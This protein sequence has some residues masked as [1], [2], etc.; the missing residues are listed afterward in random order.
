M[1]IH[2]KHIFSLLSLVVLSMGLTGCDSA[3]YTHQI[4]KAIQSSCAE[5][6]EL[7]K[8]L[9]RDPSDQL[10]F[11]SVEKTGKCEP[12]QDKA[13]LLLCPVKM[14]VKQVEL[15]NPIPNYYEVTDKISIYQDDGVWKADDDLKGRILLSILINENETLFSRFN[16]KNLK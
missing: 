10:S 8:K 6:G 16:L 7:S 1:M 12:S 3:P 2:K 4:E 13:N 14:R 5:P 9:N 15:G 11:Q